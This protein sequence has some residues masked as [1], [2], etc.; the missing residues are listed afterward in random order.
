MVAGPENPFR[1]EPNNMWRQFVTCTATVFFFFW[2]GSGGWGW[3]QAPEG[4]LDMLLLKERN[5]NQFLETEY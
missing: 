1:E 2:G 4:P 5:Q 3:S